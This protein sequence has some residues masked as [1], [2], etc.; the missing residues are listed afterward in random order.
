MKI[1]MLF[2]LLVVLCIGMIA[3]AENNRKQYQAIEVQQF[4]VKSGI[5]FPDDYRTSLQ[6]D[7]H[8]QLQKLNTF[9]VTDDQRIRKRHR[10][11]NDAS[12]RTNHRISSWK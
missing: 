3:F 1:N 2:V 6:T 11:K 5:Q 4:D 7:L 12:H 10:S 8:D 9:V